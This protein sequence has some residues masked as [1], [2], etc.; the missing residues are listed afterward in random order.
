M[1]TV[2]D[3]RMTGIDTRARKDIFDVCDS[4]HHLPRHGDVVDH[5]LSIVSFISICTGQKVENA[6]FVVTFRRLF[7]PIVVRS[8][9]L[10]FESIFSSFDSLKKPRD[11][12]FRF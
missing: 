6:Y 10:I 2:G 4:V 1:P 3:S 11:E 8:A 9:F 12:F 7:I 5:C